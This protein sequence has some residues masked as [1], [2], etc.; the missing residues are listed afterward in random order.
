MINLTGRWLNIGIHMI[1][2]VAAPRIPEIYS[3]ELTSPVVQGSAH[4]TATKAAIPT[5][6]VLYNV[7]KYPAPLCFGWSG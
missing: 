3:T 4:N 1:K 2:D 7:R 6:L 5:L